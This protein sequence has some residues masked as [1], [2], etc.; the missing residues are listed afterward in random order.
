MDGVIVI[1]CF[2]S[3][4]RHSKVYFVQEKPLD[5]RYSF[6]AAFEGIHVL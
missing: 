2:I 3:V 1:V 6:R 5:M 4:Y